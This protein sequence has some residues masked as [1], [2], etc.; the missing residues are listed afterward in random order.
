M[1]TGEISAENKMG[2]MQIDK[3]L[4]SMS[5]PM[6]V[7]M[8]VQALY[9]IVDSIFV[10]KISEATLTAVSLCF[11]IQNF[12]I[13]VLVGTNVGVNSILSRRL[14]EKNQKEVDKI[15]NVAIFLAI[16]SGIIFMM[17]GFFGTESFFAGQ[18]TSDEI[19]N[20]GMQYMRIV[21]I[22]S[23]PL[24]L[25]I[26]FEK[27]LSS[28]GRTVYNMITQMT[29]AI[30]NI[31]LDPIFIFVLN[32][33]VEGAAIATVLGQFGGL[34]V[35]IYLNITKNDDVHLNVRKI[36]PDFKIIKSIFSVGLPSIVMQS[37]GSFTIFG[38][39]NILMT[40]STTA[41]AFFGVYF[42]LQ[43]F[44]ILPMVGLAN[45]LIP[46]VAYNYGARKKDRVISAMKCSFKYSAIMMIIGILIMQIFPANLLKLFDASD[47]MIDLGVKAIRIICFAY[48]FASMSII[49]SSVFQALGSGVTSM[50]VSLTRQVI[51]LLPL[52]YFFS[53]QKNINMVWASFII[54]EA[55]AFV[56][57][58]MFSRVIL[59]RLDF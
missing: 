14:G 55:V 16:C 1:D 30:I 13:A 15:A 35:G 57:C 22:Y 20:Y 11:P 17:I 28:T 56:M 5:A 23:M 26:C 51:F 44:I 38:M 21:C 41:I 59:K 4:I 19:K 53:L 37:I 31:I 3:L 47:M 32:M 29:G 12:M 52:A 24:S 43:T 2:I 6:M 33:G 9:N 8:L 54:S 39:N 42:K 50:V 34:I 40:F 45:G 48:V 58:V 25:L 27:M 18:N 49:M 10:A 7:S 46:I 36:R